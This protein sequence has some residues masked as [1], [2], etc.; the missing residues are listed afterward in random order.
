M[1]ARLKA[2]T[3]PATLKKMDNFSLMQSDFSEITIPAGVQEIGYYALGQV[4]TLKKIVME[5]ITPPYRMRKH[6]KQFGLEDLC[7]Y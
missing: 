5:P 7:C 6:R 3:L 1:N 2:V 4:F